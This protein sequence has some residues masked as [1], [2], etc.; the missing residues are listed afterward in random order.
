MQ[1]VEGAKRG[2]ALPERSGHRKVDQLASMLRC[3]VV[4][5]AR[6]AQRTPRH[7]AAGRGLPKGGAMVGSPNGYVWFENVRVFLRDF[8]LMC[9]VEGK[10]VPLP[11]V[12]LHPDCT[13]EADGDVGRLGVPRQWAKDRGL[14]AED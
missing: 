1:S 12:L 14:L 2:I 10:V 4:G 11:V 9:A 8:Q 3:G 5:E 7:T 6:K 13:L